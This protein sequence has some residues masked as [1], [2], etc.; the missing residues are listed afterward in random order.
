MRSRFTDDYDGL[1]ESEYALL[2]AY[3]DGFNRAASD[4]AEAT[5]DDFDATFALDDEYSPSVILAD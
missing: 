5:D 2:Q 4:A 3:G 1:D